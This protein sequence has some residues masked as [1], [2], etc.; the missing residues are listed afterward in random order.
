MKNERAPTTALCTFTANAIYV[1]GRNLVDDLLGRIDFTQM[2]F[3]DIFGRLPTSAEKNI[4]DAVLVTSMEHGFSPSAIATRMVYTSAPE[5]LQGAVAAGLLGAGST[6]FGA[7][8]EAAE[9]LRRLCNTAGSLG[10]AA[11]L[12][13]QAYKQAHRALPGFGHPHHKPDDPRVAKLFSIALAQG[14]DGRHINA[15]KRFST[16]VDV[17]YGRHITINAAGAIAAVL[18]EIGVPTRLMR[19]IPLVARAAG[20]VAHIC[21]E[22]RNPAMWTM[23]K[24]A[25]E[26]VPYV[27]EQFEGRTE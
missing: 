26:A 10:E 17:V 21:E 18:C 22:M 3:L 6:V 20:L 8:E 27:P 12:E 4:L 13:A 19:G 11:H 7:M 1:R 15:L 5:A 25:D 23:M 9:L 16:A 24:A 2:L 14:V